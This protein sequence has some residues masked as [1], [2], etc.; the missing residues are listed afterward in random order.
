MSTKDND[1]ALAALVRASALEV[2]AH[3]M[4]RRTYTFDS[5]ELFRRAEVIHHYILTGE[6][7]AF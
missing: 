2:A 5:K 3:T 6:T 4:D 1:P 7:H